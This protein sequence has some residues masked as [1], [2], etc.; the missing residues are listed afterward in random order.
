M[1]WSE[2]HFGLSLHNFNFLRPSEKVTLHEKA[3]DDRLYWN[4]QRRVELKMSLCNM[5][6]TCKQLILIR[7]KQMVNRCFWELTEKGWMSRIEDEDLEGT[8][9]CAELMHSCATWLSPAKT[10]ESNQRAR[11]LILVDA[12]NY[13]YMREWHKLVSAMENLKLDSSVSRLKKSASHRE[14]WERCEINGK[15]DKCEEAH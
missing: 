4:V 15:G 12:R 9:G 6:W 13:G 3:P 10:Q 2:Y 5:L 7:N 1:F 11:A 8:A 14:T